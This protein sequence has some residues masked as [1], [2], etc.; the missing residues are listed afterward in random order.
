[1][2]MDW[3]RYLFYFLV[4]GLVTT[5]IIA[6]EESGLGLL[7]RLAALFPV[8]TWLAYFFIGEFAAPE[9]VSE[10]ARFVLIGTL[11]AWV[12]YMLAIVLLTPKLG[13]HKSLAVAIAIFI[14]IA[15]AYSAVYPK[16]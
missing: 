13:V 11:V 15:G 1:M 14:I 10:H 7:S 12:P 3:G 16:G 2:D 9:A 4:G 6:L 5:A 8:F